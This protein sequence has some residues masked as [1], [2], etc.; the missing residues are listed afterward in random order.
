MTLITRRLRPS[1]EQ[2]AGLDFF[3][4]CDRRELIKL[5]SMMTALDVPAGRVLTRAD[6]GGHEFFVIE[7]GYVEVCREGER[8]TVL[9]P[10]AFFGEM[11]LLDGGARTAT[12]TAITPLRGYVLDERELL[13]LLVSS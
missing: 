5:R 12:I 8:L 4:G 11:A 13:R 10:G 1:A 6:E 7:S 3:N 9:G 2:L